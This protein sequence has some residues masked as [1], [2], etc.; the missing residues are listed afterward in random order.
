[1]II[2]FSECRKIYGTETNHIEKVVH[3]RRRD[4]IE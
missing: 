1:M 4:S 2:N 3:E